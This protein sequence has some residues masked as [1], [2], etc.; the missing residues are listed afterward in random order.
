MG[1]SAW[2]GYCPAGAILFSKA[3]RKEVKKVNE[4]APEETFFH[5]KVWVL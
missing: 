2:E 1:A 5:L 4:K 3:D